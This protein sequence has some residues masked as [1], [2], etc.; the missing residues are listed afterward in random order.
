MHRQALDAAS[1]TPDDVDAVM[2]T[3]GSS[4]IPCFRRMLAETFGPRKL[5]DQDAFTS[6]ASGLALA[7]RDQ[8]GVLAA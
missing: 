8:A 4:L 2:H 1:L 7:A 6:V 5:L 3:G